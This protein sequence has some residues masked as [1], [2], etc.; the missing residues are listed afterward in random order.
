MPHTETINQGFEFIDNVSGRSERPSSV[1]KPV[2]G[3][4][5]ARERTAPGGYDVRPDKA[6]ITQRYFWRFIL[7]KVERLVGWKRKG[8]QIL[9][10]GSVCRSESGLSLAI[11]DTW[12]VPEICATFQRSSQVYYG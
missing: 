8:I 5:S 3:T 11:S 4:E 10:P 6:L 7:G 2:H 9:G 12:H 1:E